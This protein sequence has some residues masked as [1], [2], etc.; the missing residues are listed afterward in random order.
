MRLHCLSE[1]APDDSPGHFH[2][3]ETDMK[4]DSPGHQKVVMFAVDST[5]GPV[6]FALVCKEFV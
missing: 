2:F 5:E 1:R 6:L 3:M 4:A